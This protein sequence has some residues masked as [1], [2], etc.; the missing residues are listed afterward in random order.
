M[1]DRPIQFDAR[2]LGQAGARERG[3]GRGLGGEPSRQEV[4]RFAAALGGGGAGATAD[5]ESP[6]AA[7]TA[8]QAS[9]SASTIP[10]SAFDLFGAQASA[11]PPP[12]G[13]WSEARLNELQD[14]LRG[15]VDQ[16]LVG[17]E[18]SS[19]RRSMQL[20]LG[21]AGLPG[22]SVRVYED[23]GAWV[24]EFWCREQESF[25]R[26]AESAHPM[27]ARLAQELGTEAVW[28]V[29]AEGLTPSDSWMRLVNNS[30]EG[31][32]ATEAFA[33]QPHGSTR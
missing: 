32:Q 28:R 22:V 29:V 27:A 19:G 17:D 5:T 11:A 4:A 20:E 31:R 24:A 10:R 26:L 15:L 12:S 16:L 21:D 1:A 33:S 23:A 14:N 6:G 30:H 25:E 3:L 2:Q 8:A 18:S 9:E 13:P 7:M